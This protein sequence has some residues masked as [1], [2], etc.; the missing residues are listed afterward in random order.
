[1]DQTQSLP[2]T[3]GTATDG[4]DSQSQ[5]LWT[6]AYKALEIQDPDLV[7]AYACHLDPAL[8]SSTTPS[9]HALSPT[10]IEAVI[11][12]KLQDNEARKLVFHLGP[13]SIKVR[14]QGEKIV[15]FILWSNDFISTTVS[16][17]PYAALAWSGV[18]VLLPV[19]FPYPDSLVDAY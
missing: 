10:L 18:S 4:D 11:K 15:K 7:A 14:E 19:C 17:Q 9:Q 1:M 12:K 6:R 13:E 8:Y 16:A 2:E 5:Y 3:Q